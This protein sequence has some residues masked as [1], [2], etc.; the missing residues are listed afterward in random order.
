MYRKKVPHATP[1]KLMMMVK[2]TLTSFFMA[3][4]MR[5]FSSLRLLLMRARL[6]FSMIGLLLCNQRGERNLIVGTELLNATSQF[7]HSSTWTTDNNS[8]SRV[9]PNY[10][11]QSK[12]LKKKLN[13]PCDYHQLFQQLK[14]SQQRHQG[15]TWGWCC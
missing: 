2:L 8:T 7:W 6:L 1:Q 10:Y 12:L 9:V 13:L 5:L 11:E 14:P 3:S 4:N 15:W